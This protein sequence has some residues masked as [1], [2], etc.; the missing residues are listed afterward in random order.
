MS[1]CCVRR[2]CVFPPHL[3]QFTDT[4]TY[5]YGHSQTGLHTQLHT[6]CTR[7]HCTAN[8]GEVCS[9]VACS[10][11]TSFSSFSC[12]HAHS[13]F[14]LFAC[15]PTPLKV[16]ISC[17]AAQRTFFHHLLFLSLTSYNVF[18]I[19]HSHS[20]SLTPLA[21]IVHSTHLLLTNTSFT[22]APRQT[23]IFSG[24]KDPPLPLCK[25]QD[26]TGTSSPRGQ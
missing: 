12:T 5:T 1:R 23:A 20:F 13:L 26:P 15:L 10:S 4:H 2:V 3:L 14:F 22:S 25:Q 8:K 19:G 11:F 17:T 18:T 7:A 16:R 9:T 21:L 24:K 6:P